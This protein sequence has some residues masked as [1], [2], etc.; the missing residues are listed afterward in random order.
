MTVR[1]NCS[2][3]L[4]NAQ[5]FRQRQKRRKGRRKRRRGGEGKEEEGKAG[6]KRE[7]KRKKG[8]ERRAGE[9]GKEEEG[10]RKKKIKTVG[11]GCLLCICSYSVF[12]FGL[13]IAFK[14]A[15]SFPTVI[16]VL[17]SRGSKE[18]L[19]KTYVFPICMVDPKGNGTKH[20][21]LYP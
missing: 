20:L 18:D 8:R 2:R 17:R 4:K 14:T 6:R 9:E 11:R 19:A 5:R 21:N 15:A 16:L 3:I 1:I 12:L 7:T 13:T 10:K